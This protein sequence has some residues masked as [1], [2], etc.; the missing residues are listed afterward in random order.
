MVAQGVYLVPRRRS[1]GMGR[2]GEVYSKQA[3]WTER[4]T[5]SAT[6]EEEGFIDNQQMTEEWLQWRLPLCVYGRGREI[7]G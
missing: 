2:E 5:P 7:G 1:R 3:Q 4:R 6:T